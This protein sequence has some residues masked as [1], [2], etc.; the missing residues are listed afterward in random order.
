M[1]FALR[2]K[3][4][5]VACL[6]LLCG[7][8]TVQE[9]PMDAATS[10]RV[11]GRALAVSKRDMPDFAAFTAAAPVFGLIGAL[12]SVGVGNEIVRSNGIEDPADHIAM[13]LGA[14]LVAKY[15]VRVS[16]NPMPVGT[17]DLAQFSKATPDAD[18]LLDVRTFLWAFNYFP[19]TWNRYRVLYTARLRLID[20][21]AGRV[22]AEGKCTRIPEET[23]AAPSYDELLANGATRL[24]V[25]LR[26]AAD[27]CVN[28]FR[29][30]LL[31]EQRPAATPDF[32]VPERAP[33]AAVP[34]A[35][36]AST[37]P[38]PTETAAPSAPKADS[39][40]HRRG[41][42]WFENDR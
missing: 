21:K 9:I 5:V 16:A 24:K 18:L 15:G 4:L 41:R 23:P 12:A 8:V 38:S 11:K 2:Y 10:E 22:L 17:D 6:V 19:T 35:T 40:L 34:P 32:A 42:R 20:I 28:E 3:T 27:Y 39:R 26:I 14:D 31:L 37:P 1:N 30:R 13:T 25:E 36:A 33:S 7:C 29:P